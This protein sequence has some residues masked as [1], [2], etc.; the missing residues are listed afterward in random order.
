MAVRVPDTNTYG[1][2]DV[3]AAVMFRLCRFRLF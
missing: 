2:T 3:V 1:L